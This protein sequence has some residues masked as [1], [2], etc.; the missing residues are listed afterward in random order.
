M[1]LSKVQ[2]AAVGRSEDVA[3]CYDGASAE[4]GHLSWRHQAHLNMKWLHLNIFITIF[5]SH[6]PGVLVNLSLLPSDN[7][8]LSVGLAAGAGVGAATGDGG[9]RRWCGGGY[10]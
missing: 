5:A 8:G 3:V 9:S 4:G 6:L 1:L 10:R 7:P 2:W